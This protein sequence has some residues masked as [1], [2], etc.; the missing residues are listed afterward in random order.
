MNW[1]SIFDGEKIEESESHE[2]TETLPVWDKSNVTVGDEAEL[3]PRGEIEDTDDRGLY[4]MLN[5]QRSENAKGRIQ[6]VPPVMTAVVKT[7]EGEHTGG[8]TLTSTSEFCRIVET[9][10]TTQESKVVVVGKKKTKKENMDAEEE[11]A[12]S[13]DESTM[14]PL[15]DDDWIDETTVDGGI[16]S[17]LA[18]LRSQGELVDDK[19]DTGRY[20]K[21]NAPLRTSV[22]DN[23]VKLQYLDEYGHV[24]TPKQAFQYISWKFH[25]KWPGMKKQEKLLRDRQ[26]RLDMRSTSADTMPTLKALNRQQEAEGTAHIVLTGHKSK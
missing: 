10:I 8:N 1:D 5:R 17:A 23:D 15:N 6:F 9:P 12:L 13:D 2:P 11:G 22:N 3:T 19:L 20:N 4:E 21:S 25:G 26:K 18:L 16:S 14:V 7:E 24:M